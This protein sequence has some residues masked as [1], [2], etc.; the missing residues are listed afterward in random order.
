MGMAAKNL[1]TWQLGLGAVVLIVA[2]VLGAVRWLSGD[3]EPPKADVPVVTWEEVETETPAPAPA[4]VED[5]PVVVEPTPVTEKNLAVPFTSQA[6]YGTWDP[7]HEETCEEASMHVVIEYFKGTPDGVL[8][9][10]GVEAEL[11]ALVAYEASLGLGL[12]ITAAEAVQ[13]IEGYYDSY[14]AEVIEDPTAAD[15]KAF[16]DEGIPVIVPAAGRELGNP[17]YSGEGPLYHML[18]VRG[19]TADRFITNDVGTRH[20]E[21]YT[22]AIDTF[23]RA[24]G[25]WNNG[26]P[27]NGATRVII[28]RPA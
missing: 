3:E 24:I 14:D 13:V 9:P 27:A 1:G 11:Q 22:F 28:I 19:Y 7:M 12:S 25:D 16:I 23:M 4:P 15:I 10:A 2:L 5:E 6:P 26:D 17:F 8:P 21:N 18:V 20:G